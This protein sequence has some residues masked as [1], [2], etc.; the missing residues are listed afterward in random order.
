M[1]HK[2]HRRRII[3]CFFLLLAFY[4]VV[5]GRLYQIQVSQ[6][7]IWTDYVDRA[8]LRRIPIRSTRG[9]IFAS[10][11]ILLAQ[12]IPANSLY[13]DP[14]QI[15]NPKAVSKALSELLGIDYSVVEKKL[16]TPRAKAV[17]TPDAD[18]T[19]VEL[20]RPEKVGRTASTAPPPPPG[21]LPDSLKNLI[22]PEGLLRPPQPTTTQARQR[23]SRFVWI[24]RKLDTKEFEAVSKLIETQK[25]KG[26]AFRKESRRIYPNN[27]LLAQALGFVGSEEDGL[28]GLEHKYNGVLGGKPGERIV[29]AGPNGMPIHELARKKPEG[30]S[31]IWLTIDPVIQ[32][33]LER[34][35]DRAFA[36]HSPK[37]CFAAAMDP[38]TG[39]I[40]A[41]A[42]RPTFDPNQWRE[43]D[44]EVWKNRLLT[45]TIE[46]GSTFKLITACAALEDHR[47]EPTTPFFCP[48]KV[49][50]WDIPIRC[51]AVHS[52]VTLEQIIEKSCNT[53]IIKVGEL[54]GPKNLYYYIRKFGF[55]DRTGIDLPAEVD[56]QVR[57]PE[58][59]SGLSIGAISMGQE[60][61]VT[62]M[63]MLA[64][65]AAIANG[66]LL[67]KPQIIKKIVDPE[68]GATVQ[69]SSLDVRRRVVSPQT[70]EKVAKMMTLVTKS[71][72][73]TFAA[74]DDY[75]VAG[76]TGTS[77]KLGRAKEEGHQKYVASFVGFVPVK[78]PK[79]VVYIV[80]NEPKGEKIRGGTMAAPVFR[81]IARQI[82]LL[83]KVPPEPGA[84]TPVVKPTPADQPEPDASAA[85]DDGQAPEDAEPLRPVKPKPAGGEEEEEEAGPSDE[86]D[87]AGRTGED[88]R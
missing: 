43:Y 40:L 8:H 9:K 38:N 45:D 2:F 1:I 32:H 28:E 59:W 21:I 39:E 11:G 75:I 71:G 33:Y 17:P 84:G 26:L 10:S 23:R 48:G 55:G 67:L 70:A 34:E 18:G 49:V 30:F 51:T 36:L 78:E 77:E 65:V 85:A 37:N 52:D 47:V 80:L 29:V 42:A 25:I 64:A 72:S 31:H 63:Q 57:P 5:I 81:E 87:D 27:Q 44:R 35:L 54:L 86:T 79:V 66:G 61:A 56:G 58:Q 14:S 74:L 68:T 53:G 7:A 4:L 82:M 73:G 60:I 16:I 69:E 24:K 15:T 62:G 12:S 88:R 83:K 19:A 76:K 41:M 20:S 50:L 13:G 6:T 46:P 3:T 22:L